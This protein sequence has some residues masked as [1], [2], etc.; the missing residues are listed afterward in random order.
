[1]GFS[2]Q[3]SVSFGVSVVSDAQSKK[4]SNKRD[5]FGASFAKRLERVTVESRDAVQ[6]IKQYDTEDSFHYCDP[7]YFNSDCG[8]YRGYREEDFRDLLDTLASIKGKFLLS[9]YPSKVLQDYIDK[10]GWKHEQINGRVSV[11]RKKDSKKSKIE[12]LTWNY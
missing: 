4:I 5:S 6:V 12:C 10:F 8:H 3:L 9:S 2:S 1:M 7:P 11:A